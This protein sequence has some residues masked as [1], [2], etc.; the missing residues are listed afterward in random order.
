MRRTIVVCALALTALAALGAQEAEPESDWRLGF[1]GVRMLNGM[2]PTGADLTLSYAGLDFG[3]KGDTVLFFKA[4]G[5]YQDKMIMRD[6]LG[7]PVYNEDKYNSP[8]FQWEA[9]LLQGLA[10]RDDGDN[11]VE[12]FGFYRG[13]F[14]L[15]QNDAP[16]ALFEDA[17]GLFG[18]SLMAGISYDSVSTNRHRAKSGLYAELAGEW[19]P[20]FANAKSDFWR[21]SAQA[22]SFLTLVDIPREGG[23]LFNMY[24]ALFGGVDYAGGSSVPIYVNQSFGGRDL[25]D[26]L[27]ESVR[28][29]ERDSY[30]ASLK[31]VANAELRFVGPALG[32]E[33]IVP[34]LYAFADGGY[35]RGFSEAAGYADEAGFLASAG[36][37]LA[38]DLFGF[39]QLGAYAGVKLIEDELYARPDAFFWSISIFLHF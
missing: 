37:G 28:G 7:R 22:R 21:L 35:Y 14:D 29:Y 23:N 32:L 25:R 2:I 30:D 34:L 19:G 38:V 39:A 27:G 12:L 6:A 17:E 4:G 15:Y 11:L 18:T 3:L 26:S 36:G 13:R 10:P 8:N 31:A 20:A 5:G 1:A 33:A 16:I 24:G 9:A